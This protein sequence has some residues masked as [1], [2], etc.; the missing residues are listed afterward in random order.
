ASKRRR[1]L[2]IVTPNACT[3]C[4]KK[5]AKCDGQK[6]CGRCRLRNVDCVYEIPVRQYKENLRSEIEQQRQS[7]SVIEALEAGAV[8]GDMLGGVIPLGSGAVPIYPRAESR[9]STGTTLLPLSGT[10]VG[11]IGC[12]GSAIV[13]DGFGSGIL[14]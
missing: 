13:P 5:R 14:P 2:G 3:E 4:R 12:A 7:D 11:N 8:G 10:G 9:T 6:P 1:G